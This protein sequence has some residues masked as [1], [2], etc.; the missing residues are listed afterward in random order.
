MDPLLIPLGPVLLVA[1]RRVNVILPRVQAVEAEILLEVVAA[2]VG[3]KVQAGLG[4]V[5]GDGVTGWE[6]GE[7]C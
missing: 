5:V 7:V 6:I 4:A 2:W 3:A 1:E